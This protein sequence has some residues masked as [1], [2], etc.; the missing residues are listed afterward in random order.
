MRSSRSMSRQTCTTV[1]TCKSLVA[2][3]A[4]EAAHT[5]PAGV[6]TN[7]GTL[8]L[9]VLA[10]YRVRSR[11]DTAASIQTGVDA[12]LGDRYRLLFHHLHPDKVHGTREIDNTLKVP[13]SRFVPTSV[14]NGCLIKRWS[15][16][17]LRIV[18]QSVC[19]D[20]QLGRGQ[21]SVPR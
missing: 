13:L 12:G 17:V 21:Y 11:H 2:M 4:R 16:D 3:S 8:G 10:V 14:A 18:T 9:V 19:F 1:N 7:L 5:Q 6:L 15:S 20:V